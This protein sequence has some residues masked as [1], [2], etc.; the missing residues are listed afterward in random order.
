MLL[1]YKVYMWTAACDSVF[2][3][4]DDYDIPPFVSFDGFMEVCVNV[5]IV[6]DGDNT[7]DVETIEIQLEN[8]SSSNARIVPGS[9]IRMISIL[10]T[11][12]A[13]R[14]TGGVDSEQGR[15]EICYQGAWGSVCTAGW[16]QPDAQVVCRQLGLMGRKLLNVYKSTG[17][18]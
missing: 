1:V 11:E 6:D 16:D 2:P 8:S 17:I 3:A 10:C 9:S 4:G 5:Y 15:V 13:V 12:N 14:L 7:E 18:L